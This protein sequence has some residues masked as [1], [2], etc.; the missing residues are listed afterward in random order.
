[1]NKLFIKAIFTLL[2]LMP[3]SSWALFEARLTYGSLTSQQDLAG[4]C[5]G[6]CA[7]PSSAP[8]IVPTFGMGADVLVKLPVI[9]FGFGLR[10]EDMKLSTSASSID[11]EIKYQ[12]TALLIN[13]RW[14]DTIVHFGPIA[15][16]GLTHTGS[17]NIKESGTA[18]V[19][20]APS[21]LSS[22][23]L[24][25][26]LSVK[27][28]IVIPISVGAETGYMSFKWGQTVNSVDASTK[29]IDLSGMYIKF[30]LGIDL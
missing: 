26:E 10:T 16:V 18:K 20:L 27:P 24:G 17:M 9:P 29:D 1:M 3:L 14:I 11:A 23:S 7:S 19:D 4:V 22:Y 28:L 12:R 2:F 13:Y 5:Q 6:S 21:S 15:S 30:F 8:A 25:L